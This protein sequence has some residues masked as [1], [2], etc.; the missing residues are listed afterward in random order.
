MPNDIRSMNPIIST[1]LERIVREERLNGDSPGKPKSL[2][3]VPAP[4]DSDAA[5]SEVPQKTD[6][7]LSPRHIDLRI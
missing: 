4:T 1:F 3:P 6:D 5:S 2:R 7:P